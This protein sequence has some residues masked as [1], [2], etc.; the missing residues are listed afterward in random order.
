MDLVDMLSALL[1]GEWQSPDTGLPHSYPAPSWTVD[2]RWCVPPPR[3]QPWWLQQWHP[4]LQSHHAE[5]VLPNC[6]GRETAATIGVSWEWGVWPGLFWWMGHV[7]LYM[8]VMF[9]I[10]VSVYKHNKAF[11]EHHFRLLLLMLKTHLAKMCLVILVLDVKTARYPHPNLQ[12]L[13]CRSASFF[14]CFYSC[15]WD[16]TAHTASVDA[17]TEQWN[18]SCPQWWHFLPFSAG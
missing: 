4:H 6:S 16:Q 14:V 18:K 1:A 11:A 2:L 13:C 3:P 15:H 17:S 10:T 12:C 9:Y 8:C 7:L 5:L